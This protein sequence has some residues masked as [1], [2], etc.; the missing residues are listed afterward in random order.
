MNA[1]EKIHDRKQAMATEQ[2][3]E[4][5]LWEGAYS[6][7]TLAAAWTGAAVVSVAT[8]LLLGLFQ[9]ANQTPW[10][11]VGMLIVLMWLWLA[12]TAVYLKWKDRYWLTTQRLKHRSGILFRQVNRI[13]LID[14]D[15]VSYTQGPVQ[16]LVGVGTIKIRSSDASH[17]ELD[18]PGIKDVKTV[19][20]L[21]DDARLEE[22]RKRS[23]H[24]ESV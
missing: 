19:L 16:T 11:T 14:I 10:T 7:R 23:L 22:R 20:D 6:P 17:P 13:E 12:G 2:E 3:S 9:D 21:I 24:I 5:E 15:D 18:L 4:T 1:V 8:P